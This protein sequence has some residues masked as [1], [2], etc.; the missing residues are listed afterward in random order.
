MWSYDPLE[1]LGSADNLTEMRDA[2][3]ASVV[4]AGVGVD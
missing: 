4:S 3:A 2:F 1:L